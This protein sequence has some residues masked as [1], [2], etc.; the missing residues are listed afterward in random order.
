MALRR[1]PYALIG[2]VLALVALLGLIGVATWHSAVIHDDDPIQFVL[3]EQ[4]SG[5]SNQA[6]P[7]GPV[8]VVAHA[9]GQFIAFA[10]PL[11]ASAPALTT[12]QAW[13]IATTFLGDGSDPSKLL[14]PPRG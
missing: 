6:D 3:V 4:G 10:E 2:A 9:T 11:A 13:P 7:V 5:S 12:N 14:R 1:S 8:H